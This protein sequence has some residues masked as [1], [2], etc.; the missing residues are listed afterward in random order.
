MMLTL[1]NCFGCDRLIDQN[2]QARV[3]KA[4]AAA[5]DAMEAI[6]LVEA[7]ETADLDDMAAE[8][9]VPVLML[10]TRRW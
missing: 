5:D 10:S 4:P 2:T 7:R 1:L 6:E 9:V 8:G 3:P